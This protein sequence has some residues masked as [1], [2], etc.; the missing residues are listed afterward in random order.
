MYARKIISVGVVVVLAGA[1]ATGC[2]KLRVEVSVYNGPMADKPDSRVAHGIGLAKAIH[3]LAQDLSCDDGC[4]KY[5]SLVCDPANHRPLLQ[6]IVAYYDEL[7]IAEFE[8]KWKERVPKKEERKELL[9]VLVAY[10]NYCQV[11]TERL[12][13]P[14]LV[15]G[16]YRECFQLG[17]PLPASHDEYVAALVAIDETGRI[18]KGVA[19]SV[20]TEDSVTGGSKDV[21]LSRIHSIMASQKPG[22]L[23]TAIKNDPLPLQRLAKKYIEEMYDERYWTPINPLEVKATGNVLTVL[24]KDELGNWQLKAVSADPTKVIDAGREG[25]KALLEAAIKLSGT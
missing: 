11:V 1:M 17:F 19:D 7:G 22:V 6:E 8:D 13:M 23:L 25:A 20:I 2:S 16:F 3:D 10:G 4:K 5:R 24:V 9:S 14:E 21:F 18:L 12:G 15:R